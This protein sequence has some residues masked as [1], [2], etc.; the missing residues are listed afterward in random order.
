MVILQ[1]FIAD[2]EPREVGR[3]NWLL[4]KTYL[5]SY[6]YNDIRAIIF[7]NSHSSL[8]DF[9]KKLYLDES[10]P[11]KQTLDQ[12]SQLKQFLAE[13][14]IPLLIMIIPDLQDLSKGSPY[15]PLYQ[16]M[17]SAFQAMGVQTLNTFSGY[18]TLF[19]K[20]E[21]QLWVH[22]ND[23]HPNALGHRLMADLLYDYFTKNK[24]SETGL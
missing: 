16:K 6:F 23:P 15:E 5:G 21:S 14:K 10:I 8:F 17:E 20:R 4:Q 2:V 24:I 11:W 13:K 12:I 22:P 9:Y 18:Q 19:E 7:K 3:D 1:Y